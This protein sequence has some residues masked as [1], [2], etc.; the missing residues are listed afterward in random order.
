M[1]KPSLPIAWIT[2]LVGLTLASCSEPRTGVWTDHGQ[3]FTEEGPYFIQGVCYHPV[4]VG[5]ETRSFESLTK[6]HRESYP[7]SFALI[8]LILS[9]QNMH[10]E[11]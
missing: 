11:L 6:V 4:P 8:F 2:L 10:M 7:T 1:P 9:S 3:L 5:Q